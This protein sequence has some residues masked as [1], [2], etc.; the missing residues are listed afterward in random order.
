VAPS[1]TINGETVYDVYHCNSIDARATGDLLVSARHLNAIFE[2]RRSDGRVVW[3]MGGKPVNKDGA[4]I[5]A[6]QN[7]PGGIVLQHD[8]RYMPGNHISLFDNQDAQGAVAARAVE[9]A[10][11]FST[12]TAEP[13]FS[14]ASPNNSP[15]CCMG[16]FRRYP[17]GH[18]VIGWGYVSLGNGR[19]LTEINASGQSVLDV[20]FA[21]DYGSYRA[22][23]VPP[24]RFDVNAL[25]ATAGQ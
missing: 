5:I 19:V 21:T 8:A 14:F 25:R 13:V 10:L 17:D 2:I 6:I 11:N 20:R 18:S 22:V 9:F 24:P 12:K 15:S 4:S 7:D 3:K 1:G 16:N 23:K